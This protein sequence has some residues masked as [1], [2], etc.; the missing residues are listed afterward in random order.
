MAT[1]FDLPPGVVKSDSPN[2]ALGR[3]ADSDKIHFKGR[4]AEKW[5]GWQRWLAAESVMQGRARGATS[6]ANS[7]GNQNAAFGTHLKLYAVT[8]E[9]LLRD[10]TPIRAEDALTNPFT[11]Q[12]GSD[13]V[14]VAHTAHGADDNDFVTFANATAVG[15]ITIDGEYQ[16]SRIDNNSYTITHSA[17][18][19]SDATGGG[20]VAAEYQIN[21]GHPDTLAGSGIGAGPYGAEAYG[22]ARSESGLLIELRYWSLDNYGNNLLASPYEGGLFL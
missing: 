4:F 17:A 2:A 9:D 10:I 13:I 20:T 22:T 3:W 19:T 1:P 18:A 16:L 6:W 15:G 12:D 11:T 7:F 5:R 21:T 14:T 8:G